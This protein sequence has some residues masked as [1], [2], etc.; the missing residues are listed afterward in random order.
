MKWLSYRNLQDNLHSC[1]IPIMDLSWKTFRFFTVTLQTSKRKGLSWNHFQSSC[2]W[3]KTMNLSKDKNSQ[4]KIWYVNNYE[5]KKMKKKSYW[6]KVN[7]SPDYH[8]VMDITS[9]TKP[10]TERRKIRKNNK[11]NKKNLQSPQNLQKM[12][13]SYWAI[14]KP[15]LI[16]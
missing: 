12:L 5:K 11:I 8:L 13:S 9:V 6:K 10:M 4:I 2:Q 15:P 14:F 16:T 3:S 7:K 1:N